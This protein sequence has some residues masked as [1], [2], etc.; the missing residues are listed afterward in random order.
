MATVSNVLTYTRQMCQ[1]DSNGIT[2]AQGIL[3]TSDA[4]QD[5]IRSL[6]ERGVDAAQLQ[7]SYTTLTAG[8]GGYAWPD[9][10]F[11]LKTIELR[12]GGSSQQD[13]IQ[14]ERVDVANLQGDTSFDYL[15]VNQP[16]NHPLFDNR[17]DTYEVFPTPTT[18]N[19]GGIRIF[20]YILPSDYTTTADTIAYP[21]SLDP[22]C[23][24]AKNSYY[25]NMT[26]GKPDIAQGF[27]NEYQAR[28]NKLIRILAPKSKQPIRAQIL[29]LT[30]WE[31]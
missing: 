19:A 16:S 15:R 10:M 5:F 2:D 13:Y 18:T 3:Y 26:L 7:E 21:A 14:G 6:V 29:N 22:K 8:Q 28:L 25:Y 17:G 27:E 20:Y 23:L 12:Y 31:F 4:L 11:A 9:N 24:A 1:T 30:G